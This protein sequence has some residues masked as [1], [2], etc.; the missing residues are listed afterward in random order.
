MQSEYNVLGYRIDFYFH[1]YKLAI[2][3]DELV[4]KDRDVNHEI[5]RQKAIKKELD[6]EFIRINP[7]E[8][9][10]NIFKAINKTKR[11]IEKSSKK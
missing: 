4:H 11:Y 3:I 10:L 6:C 2:E 8:Q 7:D 9:H 1:E 5:E